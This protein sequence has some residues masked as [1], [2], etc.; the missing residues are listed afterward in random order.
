MAIHDFD[1]YVVIFT[2]GDLTIQELKEESQK[3]NWAPIMILRTADGVVVPMFR[4]PD[5]CLKFMKRNIPKDQMAGIMG[6]S[7][8]D[9]NK[10]TDKGWKIEWH[11]YP[12]LYTNR[13]GY[14]IEVEVVESDFDLH[15]RGGR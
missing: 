15:V 7:E 9:L 11:T 6:M 13:P 2:N 12:K 1:F 5:I 14:Q 3:E 4:D 8:V 10:F